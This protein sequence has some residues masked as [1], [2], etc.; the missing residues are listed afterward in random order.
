MQSEADLIQGSGWQGR[1]AYMP[2]GK[3]GHPQ[4][5]PEELEGVFLSVRARATGE[6]ATQPL[7]LGA[8][9]KS[10]ITSAVQARSGAV[11]EASRVVAEAALRTPAGGHVHQGRWRGKWQTHKHVTC[12]PF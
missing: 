6:L 10:S 12:S 2:K 1:P 11:D 8:R 4:D 7:Q 9:R 5:R 3:G